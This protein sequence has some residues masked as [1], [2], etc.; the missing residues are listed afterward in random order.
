MDLC[1]CG[2]KDPSCRCEG[3]EVIP[4]PREVIRN[5][6]RKRKP[7]RR[8]ARPRHRAGECEACHGVGERSA[9]DDNKIYTVQCAA[10]EGTGREKGAA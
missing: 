8:S 10:C 9:A 2:G 5:E 4:T 6:Q 3:L 7:K 1:G